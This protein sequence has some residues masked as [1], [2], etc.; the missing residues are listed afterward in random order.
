LAQEIQMV[1]GKPDGL[2]RA[3]HTNGQLKAE[4]RLDHGKVLSQKFWNPDGSEQE[5][6]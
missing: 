4:A 6:K 2:S 5:S 3:W 1:T